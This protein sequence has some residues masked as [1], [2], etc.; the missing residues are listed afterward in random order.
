MS[1]FIVEETTLLRNE[2]IVATIL[3]QTFPHLLLVR[4]RVYAYSYNIP[5]NALGITLD[6][7]ALVLNRV[8]LRTMA[9]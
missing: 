9:V 7:L 1:V 6:Q 2:K 5:E 8:P 3:Q 4:V